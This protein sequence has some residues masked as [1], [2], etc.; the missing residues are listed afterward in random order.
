M[1]PTLIQSTCWQSTDTGLGNQLIGILI[2]TILAAQN[3]ITSK[4]MWPQDY[5]LTAMDKGMEN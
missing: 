4:E 1:D 3:A 5:G 2:R